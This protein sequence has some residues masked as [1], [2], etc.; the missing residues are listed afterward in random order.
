MKQ[1][2][3]C[4]FLSCFYEEKRS[5]DVKST[6]KWRFFWELWYLKIG[7]TPRLFLKIQLSP[8]GS[9]KLPSRQIR[10]L[11]VPF[12]NHFFWAK[13]FGFHMDPTCKIGRIFR[14]SRISPNLS[15]LRRG[16]SWSTECGFFAGQRS[17]SSRIVRILGLRNLTHILKEQKGIFKKLSLKGST[18][19]KQ[20]P[21]LWSNHHHIWSHLF[22]KASR[23]S[24]HT[25][26]EKHLGKEASHTPR[27]INGGF[28]W[29]YGPPGRGKSS[30]PKHH[31]QVLC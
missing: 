25:G 10:F 18:I 5:F 27:K 9:H 12:S 3:M 20:S 14:S 4:K 22:S 7:V 1:S 6:E 13:L 30:E 8:L 24:S 19:N 2:R 26:S 15:S 23:L 16:S 21:W 11:A 28:T 29:E 31:F 17:P